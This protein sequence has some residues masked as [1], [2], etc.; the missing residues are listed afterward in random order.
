[1][2]NDGSFNKRD[3][4]TALGH[5]RVLELAGP[6]GQH[7]GKLMADMGAD[8]IKIE[9]PE[10]DFARSVGP[11]YK[12]MPN[13]EG[14]LYFLNFNTNK[15]SITLDMKS[16]ADRDVLRRLAA[17]ADVVI[18]S[19]QPG[20]LDSLGL[21]YKDLSRINPGLVMTSITSFGQT[22]P[23]RNYL[24]T[25]LVAQAMGGLMYIQ[26]DDTKPPCNA[27]GE[28]AY[29]L[30]STHATY[31]TL[32]ALQFR[33]KS[34]RGQQIDVSLQDVVSHL[35]FTICN[36]AFNRYIMRRT[37]KLIPRYG[38]AVPSSYYTCK[39]GKDVSLSVP[40]PAKFKEL[41]EWIGNEILKDPIW[42]DRGYRTANQE[43][44]VEIVQEFILGFTREEFVGEAQKRRI[45]VMSIKDLA[46][47]V[48]DPQTRGRGDY[49][50]KSIHPHIGDHTYP[51]APYRFTE[52]PW[53][54]HRPAPLLGQ[55]QDEVLQEL[56]K[57]PRVRRV[58]GAYRRK[59]AKHQLPL[60]GIRIVDFTQGWAGPFATRYVA[61]LGAEVI[62]VE[63][64]QRPQRGGG[65]LGPMFPEINRSKLS[66]TVDFQNRE[67]KELLKR[68]VQMSDIVIDNFSAGVL[69]R[70]GLGYKELKMWKADIIMICMSAFGSKGPYADYVAFGQ[71]MLAV[72]GVS[73]LWGYPNSPQVSR[74]KVYYTDFAS[75]AIGACC[76]MVALESRNETGKGQYIELAQAEASASTLGVGLLDYLVN[77]RNWDPMGNH[78][79]TAA[80][81]H[82]YPCRG[83]DQWCVIA[84]WTQDHWERLC[85]V[86]GKQPWTSDP[87]FA[88]LESRWKNQDALDAAIGQWTK[89]YTPYQVMHMLQRAG[90]PAGVVQSGEQLY[91]D[92][93][94]RDR[95]FIAPI[96]HCPPFG[97]MEHS[98]VVPV[99]SLT[100]GRVYGLHDLGQDN[101]HVF[102]DILGLSKEEVDRLMEKKVLY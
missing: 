38:V 56:K 60:Q 96:E 90:V 58:K 54:I 29:Q 72:S 59:P 102:S 42:N 45:P 85:K 33:R 88:T 41:V 23:Y 19:F 65:E 51:G 62:K 48:N 35:L 57:A 83:E 26:G 78:N 25:D 7:C 13:R 91:H 93:H 100:P 82:A 94:L 3:S 18:E 28:Q 8:V 98:S 40:A 5:L 47:V 52:T 14:S 95:N 1:M 49:L 69:E 81:H 67:G 34:G 61:D 39:D 27:P 66:I 36:Y 68:L 73:Y 80:P 10:G 30:T 101:Y 71:E 16:E 53:R 77:G 4:I 31:A 86:A 32:A 21:G 17:T 43:V 64:N 9:P 87:R 92:I 2:S 76:M 22:G 11:F 46:G 55:H 15:R 12:D 70:H 89:E 44:M 79:F 20:Y 37:G 63:S 6:P 84:C 74:A 50:V 99:L 97:T 24:G 75:A